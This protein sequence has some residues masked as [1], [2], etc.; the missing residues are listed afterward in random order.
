LSPHASLP[1]EPRL[2][3]LA[4]PS[5]HPYPERLRSTSWETSRVEHLDDPTVPGAP[6]GQWWPP[7][8]LEP[9]W[10]RQHGAEVD[11]VHLHFGFD[12]STP[13]ELRDWVQALRDEGVALVLTVHDL[14]NPHFTDQTEHQARLDVLVPAADAVITLTAGAAAEVR[15]RWAV[16]AEVLA[17]PHVVPLEVIAAAAHRDQARLAAGPRADGRFVVGIDLKSLRANVVAEPVVRVV[18]AAVAALP[19]AELVVDV[20][21]DVLDPAHARHDGELV[22]CLSALQEQGLLR[23]DLHDRRT[24]DELWEHLRSL[25]LVVLPYAHGTHSGWVEACHD[26][27]TTVLAPR[28]GHWVEQQPMLTFAWP[29]GGDPDAEQVATA[30]QLAHRDRPHWAADPRDRAEQQV[31]LSRRHEQLYAAVLAPGRRHPAHSA[32]LAGVGSDSA[33]EAVSRDERATRSA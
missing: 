12:A 16:A 1:A 22:R 17:H 15:R 3:V 24:D 4:I 26:V 32:G 28:T 20:H 23:V 19:H 31:A 27:G 2:R 29:P 8:A 10:V 25:D 9:G 30:V 14:V 6:Q 7:A 11:V 33:P 13:E 21:H 5:A 18:A